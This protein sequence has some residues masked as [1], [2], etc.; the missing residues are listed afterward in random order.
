MKTRT[1]END[2]AKPFEKIDGMTPNYGMIHLINLLGPDVTYV[3]TGVCKG[4]SISSVIQRCPNITKA[5]GID[6]YKPHVDTFDRGGK[7]VHNKKA[8]NHSY[9][10]AKQRILSSGQKDKVTLILE[11]TDVAINYFE[12][13]SIDFLFLDHYLNEEDVALSL[14]QWY[15]KVRPGGCFAGHDYLYRGVKKPIQEFREK[16][17]INSPLSV[18]GAE[19]MWI[20]GDNICTL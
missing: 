10:R 17:D 7:F 1:F 20:K 4:V 18:F 16:Y 3:E 12:D 14:K 11:H 2:P 19:W 8:V 15:N 5:Y 6:F 13:N 9:Q